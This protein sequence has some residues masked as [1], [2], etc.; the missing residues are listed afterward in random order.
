MGREDSFWY[1]EKKTQMPKE[2]RGSFFEKNISKPSDEEKQGQELNGSIRANT[3]SLLQR[4][5]SNFSCSGEI[6]FA[7][8]RSWTVPLKNKS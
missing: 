7:G 4:F 6:C 8:S 5:T 3:F 1:I 2:G